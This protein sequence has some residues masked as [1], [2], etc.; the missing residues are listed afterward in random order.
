ML[1]P[2]GSEQIL[3]IFTVAREVIYTFPRHIHIC[4]QMSLPRSLGV[5]LNVWLCK[6]INTSPSPDAQGTN[7]HW[8]ALADIALEARKAALTLSHPYVP[9]QSSTGARIGSKSNIDRQTSCSAEK[10]LIGT[11][12]LGTFENELMLPVV[13]DITFCDWEYDCQ[14]HARYLLQSHL[15]KSNGGIHHLAERGLLA[16]P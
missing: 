7:W 1:K 9:P 10:W 6:R 11:S 13:L 12:E 16:C 14:R 15:S 5:H 2:T 4:H 3:A 8:L